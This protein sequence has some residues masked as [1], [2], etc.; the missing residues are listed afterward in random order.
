LSRVSVAFA[1]VLGL[2]AVNIPAQRRDSE[3]KPAGNPEQAVEKSGQVKPPVESS[4]SAESQK[5]TPPVL[6]HH[7]TRVGGRVLRYA[8]TS[9]LMSIRN[10]D[11]DEIEA[12]MFF[13]AYTLEPNRL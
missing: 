6:T 4:K 12:D 9:G 7:E 1:I 5:E 11:S 10:S 13:V 2:F 8:A 3:Q